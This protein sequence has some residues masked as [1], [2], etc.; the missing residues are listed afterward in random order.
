MH[1]KVKKITI[2]IHD[3]T[4]YCVVEFENNITEGVWPFKNNLK[5][6]FDVVKNK[7]LEYV[8]E[9][10]P[11]VEVEVIDIKKQGGKQQRTKCN[12]S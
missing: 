2:L 12:I 9:N 3:G 8:K 5:M 6:K 10:F 11:G 7:G 1:L 4:D